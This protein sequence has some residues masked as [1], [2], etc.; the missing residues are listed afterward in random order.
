MTPGDLLA[1]GLIAVATAVVLFV[2]GLV[3][4]DD[5]LVGGEVKFFRWQIDPGWPAGLLMSG[6]AILG[7]VGLAAIGAAGRRRSTG[8]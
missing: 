6:G 7:V 5:S 4:L 1:V 8:L 3:F 2:A